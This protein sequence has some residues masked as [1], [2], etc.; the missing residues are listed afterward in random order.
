MEDAVGLDAD[1]RALVASCWWTR[2]AG[3]MTSW[4]GWRHVRDDLV[5]EGSPEAVVALANRAVEDEYRHALWCRDWAVR[6][7]HPG[8]DVTPRH[9]EPL[10]WHGATER[11]NRL[12]RITFACFTET[13]GSFTL[14]FAR[15]VIRVPELRKLNRR[16]LADELQ[17]SR[18]G[19]AHL[20]TLASDDLEFV[21]A[22]TP[23]LFALLSTV[24]CAG[25]QIDREDL[26]P[27]GYFTPR[28]L[29]RAHDEAVASVIEPGLS[30]FGIGGAP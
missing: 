15:D 12:L 11:Q 8:G 5:A 19:W 28:L 1:A 23:K 6:F 20:S 25:D 7:G 2:A 4:V 27:Y 26:V 18:A 16:H 24:T 29:R 9:E 17:H 30:H 10:A 22:Q 14:K 21:G 3:E 13:V